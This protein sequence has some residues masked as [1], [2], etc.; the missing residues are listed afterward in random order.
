MHLQYSEEEIWIAVHE[1]G[2]ALVGLYLYPRQWVSVELDNL[3]PHRTGRCLTAVQC[4]LKLMGGMAAEL[5]FGQNFDTALKCSLG[6]RRRLDQEF[7]NVN[8][9]DALYE[10]TRIVARIRPTLES[11]IKPLLDHGQMDERPL[12]GALGHP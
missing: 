12:L 1:L 10:A 5:D 4:P 3:T 2:H 8:W 9:H 11:L 7:P 6:D